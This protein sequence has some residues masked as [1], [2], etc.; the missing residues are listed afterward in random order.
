MHACRRSSQSTINNLTRT[1][2]IAKIARQN[3]K[4]VK[5]YTSKAQPIAK[6]RAKKIGKIHDY[7][8]GQFQAQTPISKGQRPQT[9]SIFLESI[10]ID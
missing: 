9:L 10:F 8:L 5:S 7:R 4:Y 3:A 2:T 6:D 1:G